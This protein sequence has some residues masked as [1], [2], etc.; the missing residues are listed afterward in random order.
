MG[1]A[2]VDQ[3]QRNAVQHKRYSQRSWRRTVEYITSKQG[4]SINFPAEDDVPQS[5][6]AGRGEGK[7]CD[8]KRQ[9]NE[10]SKKTLSAPEFK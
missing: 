4:W 9:Q 7:W 8:P 2:Y 6:I 1:T 3:Q 10:H 5:G